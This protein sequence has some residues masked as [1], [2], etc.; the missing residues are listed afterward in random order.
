VSGSGPHAA[1]ARSARTDA[2][3]IASAD[4]IC[5]RSNE[6]LIRVTRSESSDIARNAPRN[7]TIELRAVEALSRLKPPP[8][9][10]GDWAQMLAYR[11]T[12]ALELVA[13]ARDAKANNAAGLRAL[14]VSK[15]RVRNK[16][17]QLAA[18]DGFNDCTQVGGVTAATLFSEAAPAAAHPGG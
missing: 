5:R 8:S 16:L 6:E 2:H 9:L 15:R 12:L 7:A 18:H 11:R 3:F 1:S 17:T 13:L 4:A 10:A 14:G